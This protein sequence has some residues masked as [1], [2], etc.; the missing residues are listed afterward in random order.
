MPRPGCETAT[1]HGC[2]LFN[3]VLT[4]AFRVKRYIR[5]RNSFWVNW[6]RPS[7]RLLVLRGM[8]LVAGVL[9]LFSISSNVRRDGARLDKGRW[10][11]NDGVTCK[12]F[13]GAGSH[14]A[15][16]MSSTYKRCDVDG[17]GVIIPSNWSMAH[18]VP[19]SMQHFGVLPAK[20]CF[21]DLCAHSLRGPPPFFS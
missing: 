21:P 1:L 20:L 14:H 4:A 9:L 3:G 10:G 2:V 6:Q 7:Y 19:A 11:A 12:A 17:S 13:F 15:S 8:F 16:P 5:G 18:D